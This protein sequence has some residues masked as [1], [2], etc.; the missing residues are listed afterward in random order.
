MDTLNKEGAEATKGTKSVKQEENWLS[1]DELNKILEAQERLIVGLKKKKKISE[2]QYADLLSHLVLS[3]YTKMPPRRSTD[4]TAMVV[5]EP[6]EEKD[7]NYFN[8]G[9]FYFNNFKTKKTYQQQVV[10]VTKD[11]VDLLKLYLKFKPKEP[12]NLLVSAS[13]TP[14]TNLSLRQMLHKMTG[15]NISTQMLR[16]IYV[17][18]KVSP[19]VEKMNDTAEAMGTSVQQLIATYSK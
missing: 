4:Y 5:S 1:L 11:M 18:D 17:T 19:M 2:E 6:T 15:K 3:L 12:N 16:N 8:N 9:H 14:L 13:G 10:K 7:K